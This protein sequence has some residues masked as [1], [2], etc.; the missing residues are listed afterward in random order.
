M[1]VS[2]PQTVHLWRNARA[3]T[4]SA[5]I[6][7]V[8]QTVPLMLTANLHS[9]F[10]PSWGVAASATKANVWIIFLKLAKMLLSA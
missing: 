5:Q 3:L 9:A 1:N 8:G 4:A 6:T 7:N 2:T 10:G